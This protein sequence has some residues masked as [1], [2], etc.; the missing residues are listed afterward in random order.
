MT[1]TARSRRRLHEGVACDLTGARRH[2]QGTYVGAALE[3][4]MVDGVATFD[5]VVRKMWRDVKAGAKTG[6]SCTA[7]TLVVDAQQ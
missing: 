3:Q 4:G 1:T 7:N 2:G 5:D 6:A